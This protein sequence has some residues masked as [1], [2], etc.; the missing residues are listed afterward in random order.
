M[1]GAE[2][3]LSRLIANV[4]DPQ[5]GERAVI[6]TDLPHDEIKDTPAWAERRQMAAEWHATFVRFGAQ[7]GYSV[8][9]FVTYAATGAH[10]GSLP[11]T[12][13]MGLARVRIED[14]LAPATLAVALTQF[15]A[16]APLAAFCREFPHLRVASLPLAARR[17]E[18]TALRA[19]YS[20]IGPRTH[21]LAS[22]LTEAAAARVRFD[23][24]HAF[25]FDLRGRQGH[26]DDGRLTL[27]KPAPRFI[28]L[29]GGE[30]YLAPYEGERPGDP[31]RT[32]G[33]IPVREED[34]LFVLRVERNRIVDVVGEGSHAGKMRDILAVDQA[35]RNIAELGLGCNDR[36]VVWGNIL[37]DEKAGFHW[38]YGRSDQL[39][40]T[41]GPEAF[42]DPA[43]V[44]HQDIVYARG[45]PVV[46]SSLTLDYPDGS[47]E[48][49]L[50][51]GWYPAFS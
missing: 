18:Q 27:D 23:T 9:P 51:D 16:S 34:E 35:R 46:A 8:S 33:E 39:G 20:V 41:V 2:F 48:E 49:I 44:V 6:M 37:E 45:S 28:N 47:T 24:G 14:V 22:K 10:N 13:Q 43:Y 32:R 3:D 11:R 21:Q 4:F 38:A 30:A 36:A 19:D 17:M 7:H 15:S 42:S 12:V 1:P 5:L 31:S 29:P 26:A 50:R 40:G 25:T